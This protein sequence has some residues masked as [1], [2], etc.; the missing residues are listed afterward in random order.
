M[1]ILA[2][3]EVEKSSFQKSIWQFYVRMCHIIIHY[4]LN[5]TFF[6]QI[7]IYNN[8]YIYVL[9]TGGACCEKNLTLLHAYNKGADHAAHSC[10]L[11]LAIV[12]H[13]IQSYYN[14]QICFVQNFYEGPDHTA[15]TCN[16]IGAVVNHF[17][18]S[19][20]NKIDPHRKCSFAFRGLN[21]LKNAV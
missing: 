1:T 19:V 21:S 11:I 17:M 12:I 15:H 18:T 5:F 6:Y 7:H 14:I 2:K 4:F 8:I 3:V 20:I 9:I 16:L 13:S 10:S